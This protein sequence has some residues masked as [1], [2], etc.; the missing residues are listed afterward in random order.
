MRDRA[1]APPSGAVTDVH[2]WWSSGKDS[3]WA[4]RA[5]RADPRYRVVSLVT[6]VTRPFDRVAIHGVRETLLR[7]QADALGL[8]IRIVDLPFPASNDAYETAVRPAIE[9]AARGGVGAMAFG[10]LFLEDVRAYR[11]SL[12]EGSG[13]APIFPLWGFET[14]VLAREMIASGLEARVTCLDPRVVPRELAGAHFD[15]DFLDALPA[16]VDPCGERGEFHTCVTLGPGFA[17][18]LSVRT[19]PTVERDG[20]VFTDLQP[21]G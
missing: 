12:L 18:P 20:F 21:A 10:D 2:L 1:S 17:T 5:L 19:G 4:L 9:D 13:I 15:A 8:P 6:T 3:A 11:E 7:R 16:T 14:S